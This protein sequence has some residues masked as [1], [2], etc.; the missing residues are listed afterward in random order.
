MLKTPDTKQFSS[1]PIYD[2]EVDDPQ[3]IEVTHKMK[4]VSVEIKDDA[5]FVA[6]VDPTKL[7]PIDV[8]CQDLVAKVNDSAHEEGEYKE[9][10]MQVCIVQTTKVF[11]VTPE[12]VEE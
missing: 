11:E 5:S 10:F 12:P 2:L 3:L 6:T 8:G 1:G 7:K 4:F 9:I